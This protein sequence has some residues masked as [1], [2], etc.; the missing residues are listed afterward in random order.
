MIRR[1]GVSALLLALPLLVLGCSDEPT[2]P[3][4]EFASGLQ[5]SVLGPEAVSQAEID[6]LGL[7]FDRVDSYAVTIV[8]A[9]SEALIADVTIDIAAASAIHDLQIDVPEDALGRTVTVTL[10]AFDGE[11]ELY[12]SVQTVTLSA[13]PSGALDVQVEIR[14][15]GPGIR[16][17]LVDEQGAPV[18]GQTVNLFDTDAIVDAVVTEDDGTYLFLSVAPGTY[19]IR[20]NVQFGQGSEACP[21]QREVTVSSTTAAILADFTVVPDCVTRVLVLSGGDFDDTEGAAGLLSNDAE[22]SVSTFFHIN[23]LPTLEYLEQFEVVLVFMNGLFD[24]SASLGNRLVQ[25]A[26][27]GGN[28]VTASFYYQGRSDS[29][30]G[31]VGWGA[32]EQWDPFTALVNPQTGEGGATY[33]TVSLDVASVDQTHPITEVLNALSSTSFSSGVQAK[34]DTQVL[35]R[36]DDGAPLVGY[37]MGPSGQRLVAV[38]LFPLADASITGDFEVLWHSVVRWAGFAPGIPG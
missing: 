25:Y 6:A 34:S 8:D 11:L 4:E 23:Q 1:R 2:G 17:V 27:R 9:V 20:P 15:T 14:Y 7:A 38:S 31:S 30:L 22:L 13:D 21:G 36:W 37:R 16:G 26:E 18:G 35:A 24:E 28:I 3:E 33:Q 29:G 12:R 19:S 5:L 32:L 10:V